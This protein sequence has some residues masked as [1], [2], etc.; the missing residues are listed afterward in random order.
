MIR[1][2]DKPTALTHFMGH[3]FSASY[4]ELAREFGEP[5][6]GDGYKVTSEWSLEIDGGVFTIYDWKERH[7]PSESPDLDFTWHIGAH[8]AETAEAALQEVQRLLA[9][10]WD[11]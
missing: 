9:E 2:T 5:L 11:C 3:R 7:M 1:Q 6:E 4:N 10:F 8:D